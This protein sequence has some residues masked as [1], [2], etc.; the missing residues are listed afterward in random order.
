MIE[1]F[2]RNFWFSIQGKP[3]LYFK[4]LS[5]GYFSPNR[6]ATDRVTAYSVLFILFL[7]LFILCQVSPTRIDL[8]FSL[9]DISYSSQQ[10]QLQETLYFTEGTC[11]ITKMFSHYFQDTRESVTGFC[12]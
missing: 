6:Y 7:L 11:N 9:S 4:G 2:L 1:L 10:Q 8:G 5:F 3:I 12:G